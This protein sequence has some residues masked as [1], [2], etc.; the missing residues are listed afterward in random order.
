MQSTYNGHHFLVF[1]SNVVSGFG[2][3]IKGFTGSPVVPLKVNGD[4]AD[5]DRP[6]VPVAFPLRVFESPN[7]DAEKL[8][9]IL[10]WFNHNAGIHFS[11]PHGLEQYG[12]AAWGVRDVTQGSIE[13]LLAS[14]RYTVARRTLLE[15]FR[16][17]YDENGNWPQWFMH[18]SFSNLQQLHAHGDICFWPLKAL[19]DY[20]EASNDFSILSETVDFT[21]NRTL[22]PIHRPVS[23]LEHCDRIFDLFETRVSPDTWLV[24]YGEGDWD[25]TLQPS[26]R[27]MT[28]KMVSAWTVALSFHVFR[29]FKEVCR[30]AG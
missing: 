26:D 2:L 3:C 6:A 13:W 18:G 27:N 15:V 17:Q 1:Q 9:E 24:N 29:Q 22:E 8:R 16:H 25:D 23:I 5:S 19:C 14:Q 21:S 7:R 28:T 12:G 20:V 30:R 11:S 10:P 4:L